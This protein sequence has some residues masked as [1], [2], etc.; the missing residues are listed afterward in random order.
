VDVEIIVDRLAIGSLKLFQQIQ[1]CRWVGTDDGA[2]TVTF[3]V[4]VMK[5]VISMTI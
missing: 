1:V 4:V 2:I 3:D 5:V